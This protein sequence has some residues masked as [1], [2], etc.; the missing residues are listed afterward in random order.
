[1]NRLA[2]GLDPVNLALESTGG[3]FFDLKKF[4]TVWIR[5]HL[6][7]HVWYHIYQAAV[8]IKMHRTRVSFCTVFIACILGGCAID[9]VDPKLKVANQSRD[10]LLVLANLDYPDTSVENALPFRVFPRDTMGLGIV[11]AE[12]ESILDSTGYVTVYVTRY[13]EK[14]KHKRREQYRILKKKVLSKAELDSLNW[15]VPYP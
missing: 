13:S 5:R 6:L 3:G 10:S 14:R 2:K 1:M 12:W 8:E 11:N 4:G 7:Y 15:I 9:H